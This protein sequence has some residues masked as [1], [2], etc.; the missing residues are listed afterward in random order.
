[1]SVIIIAIFK[2]STDLYFSAVRGVAASR[3]SLVPK[4]LQTVEGEKRR[5]KNKE[6]WILC[7][8]NFISVKKK[9]NKE[10]MEEMSRTGFQK[11]SIM[12]LF[13]KNIL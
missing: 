12:Q 8:V 3:V 7:Y 4:R 13:L 6:E 9:Q 1:M 10:D 5:F 2:C 11:Y